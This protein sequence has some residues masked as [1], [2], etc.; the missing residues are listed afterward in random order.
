VRNALIA[1]GA[2]L[3]AVFLPATAAAAPADCPAVTT[4]PAAAGKVPARPACADLRGFDLS[5][6]RLAGADLH[7]ADLTG[8]SLL[9][10]DLTGA[11]LHDANLTGANLGQAEL[12]G[13]NLRGADLTGAW[14]G[15]V[16]LTDADLRDAVLRNT[17][18]IQA[19]MTGADVRGADLT[20]ADLTQAQTGGVALPPAGVTDSGAAA[21]VPGDD[22]PDVNQEAVTTGPAEPQ[23]A[24]TLLWPAA[25]LALMWWRARLRYGVRHRATTPVRFTE[26]VG[27]VLGTGL[28]VAG[29]YLLVVGALRGFAGATGW[30]ADPGPLSWPGAGPGG[31]LASAAG[32][33]VLGWLVL[34]ATRRRVPPPPA[35]AAGQVVIGKPTPGAIGHAFSMP[36]RALAIGVAIAGLVDLVA[37]VVAYAVDRLPATGPW[38][39]DT[40]VGHLTFVAVTTLI[41]FRSGG[42]A[43]HGTVVAAPSGVVF[44]GA[45]RE[46]FLWLSGKSAGGAPASQALPW[47]AL[48]H[49]HLIRVLGTEHPASAMITVRQS[50]AERPN[51]YPGELAVT[52][53]Q[54]AGLRAALPPEMITEHTR[55]PR[56]E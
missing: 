36:V 13:A 2:V 42:S 23:V 30:A 21:G 33:F 12:A 17:V 7:G 16:N 20:G 48:E 39:S 6:A 34:L 29:L 40:V 10:A 53:A 14:A 19:R 8:V 46:P 31:Q 3:A 18:L 37:V 4:P 51:E 52:P 5:Q 54:V 26:V 32:A 45:G 49:V 1:I 47:E 24:I 35:V 28:T 11:D 56:A 9:Q 44:A 15:Q 25:T 22:A 41:L 27:G 55:A 43:R 50:G 38:G